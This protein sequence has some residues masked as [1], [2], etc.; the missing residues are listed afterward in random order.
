[1]KYAEVAGLKPGETR[2]DLLKKRG[3]PSRPDFQDRVDNPARDPADCHEP[4]GCADALRTKALGDVTMSFPT[5]VN[6]RGIGGAV[7]VNL[8]PAGQKALTRSIEGI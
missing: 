2:L 6:A 3:N 4:R 1:M 8:A 5:I 7:P